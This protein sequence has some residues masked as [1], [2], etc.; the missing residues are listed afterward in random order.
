[1]NV[2]QDPLAGAVLPLTDRLSFRRCPIGRLSRPLRGLLFDMGDVLHDATLWRRWLLHLLGRMGLH[3]NY[4]CFYHIWDRDF[5][6]DVHRGERPFCEALQA[7]LLSVGLSPAQIDE[8]Q[9]ACQA[10]RR[11]WEETARPLPGVKPTL[12]RLHAAGY[13]LGVLSDSEHPSSGL[14]DQL[15]RFGLSGLFSAVVSSIDLKQT[16]P[17]PIGYR[18]ALEAMR[19]A[20][21]Q[22][23]FVGHD[24]A[25]LAG[26]A[27]VGLQTIAF[28]FDPDAK[29]DVFIA[30]FDELLEVVSAAGVSLAAAG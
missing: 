2:P 24:T 20:P 3:T 22:A 10:R 14:R 7:F 21:E 13:T 27:R 29:A 15:D 30:R 17:H 9:A 18:T 25:E 16:K 6:P 1:M 28:N 26:A 23:A 8:V 12:A 11:Q 19:L 5:L 4:R